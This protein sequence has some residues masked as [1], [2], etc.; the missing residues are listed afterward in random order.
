M[1]CENPDGPDPDRC[2]TYCSEH[3]FVVECDDCGEPVR[4]TYGYMEV[5]GAYHS[6]CFGWPMCGCFPRHKGDCP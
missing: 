4:V 1:T 3:P 2:N 6:G 5:V